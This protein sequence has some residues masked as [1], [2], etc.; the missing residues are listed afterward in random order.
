[1]KII[2]GKSIFASLI[3]LLNDTS[4]VSKKF[5]A[6]CCVIVEAPSNLLPEIMFSIFLM[7]ALVTPFASIPGW[8]KKF[9]SSAERN[10]FITFSWRIELLNGEM[11]DLNCLTFNKKIGC[12]FG[13]HSF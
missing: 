10:E 11:Q 13:D 5:F 6:T 9:L 8:L 2:S 1:M 7:K 12:L 4:F 3:F